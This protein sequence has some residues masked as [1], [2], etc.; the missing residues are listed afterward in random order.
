MRT[1]YYLGIE[2]PNCGDDLL[3]LTDKQEVHN[4]ENPY[5]GDSDEVKCC[6]CDFKSNVIADDNGV[7]VDDGNIN[8]IESYY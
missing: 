7:Y 2:C 6:E 1:W 4:G 3:V 5:V 8:E